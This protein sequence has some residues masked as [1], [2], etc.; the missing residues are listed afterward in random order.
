M[1]RT[2]LAPA[3]AFTYELRHTTRRTANGA[4]RPS[5][6]VETLRA[7]GEPV[8]KPSKRGPGAYE[9]IGSGPIRH[10]HDTVIVW[11]GRRVATH[12]RGDRLGVERDADG[13]LRASYS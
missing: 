3:L 4:S 13:R 7:F 5:Y 2:D 11:N 10:K 6:Y 8:G 12:Q 9:G 1:I